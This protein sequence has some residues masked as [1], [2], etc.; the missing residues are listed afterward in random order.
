MIKFDGKTIFG[1]TTLKQVGPIAK[2]RNLREQLPG[3]A[4][5]RIYK[6]AGD[7][8]DTLSWNIRGRI[9]ALS[10]GQ[11]ERVL[12]IGVSYMDGNLYQFVTAGGIVCANCELIDY[13]QAADI[14]VCMIDGIRYATCEVVA[15]VEQASP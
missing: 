14:V 10:H 15:T 5:Y 8:P 12:G 9:F 7:G 2:T 3:V 4:G 1:Q 11:L 13:R 6:L